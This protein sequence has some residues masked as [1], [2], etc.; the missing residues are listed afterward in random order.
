[1]AG[2]LRDVQLRHEKV[3][4]CGGL[5]RVLPFSCG[6]AR[7]ALARTINGDARSLRFSWRHSPFGSQYVSMTIPKAST[8]EV[9]MK[10]HWTNRQMP[11]VCADAAEDH[12]ALLS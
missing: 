4:G 8:E 5:V 11:K 6:R 1:M 3:G 12:R 2:Q 7:A 9:H 10:I